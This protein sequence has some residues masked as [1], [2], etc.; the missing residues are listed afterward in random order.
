M[1]IP[2]LLVAFV[3]AL[4]APSCSTEQSPEE[5]AKACKALAADVKGVDLTTA[6]AKGDADQIEEVAESLDERIGELRDEDAHDAAIDIHLSLHAAED[7]LRDGD[8][9]R[10]AE[11]MTKARAAAQKAA[12][13]C[14]LAPADF[15]I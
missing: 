5:K 13:A 3:A 6:P 4:F 11:K 8:T 12:T 14:G 2:L 10:A 1:R 9:D 7:A 15:G